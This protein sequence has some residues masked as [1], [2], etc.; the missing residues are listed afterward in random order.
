[1]KRNVKKKFHAEVAVMLERELQEEAEVHFQDMIIKIKVPLAAIESRLGAILQ[2][3][4][5]LVEKYFPERKED[6]AFLIRDGGSR[7][8]NVFKI[9]KSLV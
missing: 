3:I 1:M 7:Y 4:Q 6:I 5:Q 2:R 9:W 8:E